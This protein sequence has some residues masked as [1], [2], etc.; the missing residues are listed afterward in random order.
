[1]HVAR[2]GGFARGRFPRG[3]RRCKRGGRARCRRGRRA[4]WLYLQFEKRPTRDRQEIGEGPVYNGVKVYDVHSHV[5]VPPSSNAFVGSLMASNTYMRSP[6]SEGGRGQA[7][8]EE[9]RAAAARHLAY[10]DER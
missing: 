3:A 5:S 2:V 1:M 7:T 4:S 9:F 6:L 10:M 8:E